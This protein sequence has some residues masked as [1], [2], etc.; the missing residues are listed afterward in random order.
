MY[1]A[2]DRMR[3]MTPS[4]LLEE[5]VSVNTLLACCVVMVNP[6][7][8]NLAARLEYNKRAISRACG[9]PRR[10]VVVLAVFIAVNTFLRTSL[11]HYMTDI[12]SKWVVLENSVAALVVG[13]LV[14]GV[15]G[16][17]VLSSAWKLGFFC[18]F[19]GDYFGILLDTRVTG[20]PFNVVNDP[21]YWGSFLIYLGGSIQY[22]SAVALLLTLCIGLSYV[23]AMRFEGPFTSM[24]YAKRE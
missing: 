18:T 15:G 17:L 3:M 23:I 21:M 11:V 6:L 4:G 8:W 2:A 5:L 9:G 19:L 20:F 10:G 24:I 13:Y 12:S 7:L 16:V 22:A 14:I 1:A